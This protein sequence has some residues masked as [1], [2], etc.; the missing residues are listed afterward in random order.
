MLFVIE[1]LDGSGKS[2][3]TQMMRERLD[4]EGISCSFLHFP[5]LEEAP[6]GPAVAMYLRGELGNAQTT[7]P[8]LSG[9]LYACD[10]SAASAQLEAGKR[11]GVLLLDRYYYSNLAYQCA[12]ASPEKKSRVKEWLLSLNNHF[13]LPKPD[14]AFYLQAPASFRQANLQNERRGQDRAYLQGAADIHEADSAF[15]ERVGGEYQKLAQEMPEL[16]IVDC[17]PGGLMREA[18]A[19]HEELFSRIKAMLPSSSP[20]KKSLNGS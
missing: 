8:M 13:R 3:Q 2:A 11:S 6:F 4:K 17:A 10:Q 19:I 9:L 5:R 7:D 12:K 1:G 20:F 14:A 18:Q 15:Q 16:S